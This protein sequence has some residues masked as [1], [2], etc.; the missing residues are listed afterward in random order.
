MPPYQHEAAPIELWREFHWFTIY[1]KA[2]REAFA[3]A[4]IGTLG[5]RI[6][7]RQIKVDRL[8]PGAARIAV[9]PLFPGYLSPRFCPKKSLESIECTWGVLR[10]D[11]RVSIQDGSFE[12]LMG[13]VERWV[14]WSEFG[15]SYLIRKALKVRLPCCSP[16]FV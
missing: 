11:D 5:V 16:Q 15:Q 10:V 13:R 3:A 7:L 6:L 9:K 4:N 2:R 14:V 8:V 1:M 12:G